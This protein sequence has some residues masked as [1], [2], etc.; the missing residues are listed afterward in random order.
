M[1]KKVNEHRRFR[2]LIQKWV[3]LC[4]EQE[5]LERGAAK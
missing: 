2:A 5:R 1:R 4:V 3:D